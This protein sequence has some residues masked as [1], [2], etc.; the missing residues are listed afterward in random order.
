MHEEATA[1]GDAVQLS[2]DVLL[3]VRR[4]A[5]VHVTL[6]P[7]DGFALCDEPTQVLAWHGD[8]TRVAF[9]VEC[10]AFVDV[11][12]AMFTASIVVGAEVLR[13]RSY[14]FVSA[15]ALTLDDTATEVTCDLERLPQTY[16]EI[17]FGDLE[18][19]NLVGRGNFGDAYRARYR[20]QDVVV[21]TL[22]PSEFGDNQDQ[23]VQEF[24]HEAAVL[25]LFGHHPNIVPFVGACTDL[26]QPLSLVTEYLPFGSLED[27]SR[28][29]ALSP[30]QKTRLLYDAANG[31]L[32]IHEGGFI[33][34]D[35]AARN[36]LVD[37]GLRA[38]ICDFGLC[39]RVRSFGG[40]HF[41]EGM[42]PLKY[43]APESLTPPHAFSYQSDAYS[44]GV[45]VWETYMETP[46]YANVPSHLAAARIL[47]GAR[48]DVDA[49]SIPAVHHALLA[50][51][52]QEDPSKRPSM[53][54]IVRHFASTPP[55]N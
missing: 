49:A 22:R 36:C 1:E 54:D 24:R 35:I 7:P 47:E 34:R 27:Q 12:Q 28:E 23:I 19:K 48:L 40:S 30:E 45:L 55:I 39:R 13:L 10:G 4:G 3:R 17:P 5:L 37:D 53:T 43:M 14:L 26:S 51:C 25:S 50:A 9:R 16:E 2:R 44:F 41:P 42:V 20:G 32:N 8:V 33:H 6:T 15:S 46:P 21:K 52:F 18:M 38:K 29:H 31:F 11:G